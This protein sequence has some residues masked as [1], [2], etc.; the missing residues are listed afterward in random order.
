MGEKTGIV[1]IPPRAIIRELN[2]QQAEIIDLDEPQEQQNRQ[3][4]MGIGKTAPYLPRVYCAILK[5]VVL[6]CIHLKLDKIYIDV[7]SGK[8]DSALHVS[9]ILENMLD[10]P[11]IRT[12]NNDTRGAGYPICKTEMPLMEK[13]A[14]I[15]GSVGEA[16]P[17]DNKEHPP[18]PPTAGFWGV[19][20]KDWGLLNLFPDTTHVYGWTRCM[21]N[22]TPADMDLESHVN[23]DIPTVFFAQSFCAKTALALHLARLHPRG[24]FVD[25]DITVS[26]SVR[27]KLEAFF[28][29]CEVPV[30]SRNKRQKHKKNL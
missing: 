3:S 8:C 27:A 13:M 28:E 2:R 10:I 21:E 17:A 4:S 15:T 16:D 6:N 26:A 24:L 7:G 23:P 5:T 12:R 20:P 14:A 1:G 18:C 25:C 19:P 29:L 11:V 9:T 22:K 30:T